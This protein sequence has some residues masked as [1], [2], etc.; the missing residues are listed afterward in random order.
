MPRKPKP[1]PDDPEQSKRLMDMAPI[2]LA[3]E[4]RSLDV[5]VGSGVDGCNRR[6]DAGDGAERPRRKTVAWSPSHATWPSAR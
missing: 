2:S 5:V 3:A 6:A 1:A 4:L